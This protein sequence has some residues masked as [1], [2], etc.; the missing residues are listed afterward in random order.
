MNGRVLKMG[1]NLEKQH[2]L[3]FSISLPAPLKY[4][5]HLVQISKMQDLLIIPLSPWLICK[6]A[7]FLSISRMER[8]SRT[9]PL[10]QNCTKKLMRD[11]QGIQSKFPILSPLQVSNVP[12]VK[13]DFSRRLFDHNES[14]KIRNLRKPGSTNED[15]SGEYI[16][17]M[18]EFG[19]PNLG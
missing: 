11:Q 16:G 4:E 5:K 6:N 1:K 18:A 12:S 10:R 17:K 19:V 7:T 13:N 15:C 14:R 9:N 2:C 3:E 8:K